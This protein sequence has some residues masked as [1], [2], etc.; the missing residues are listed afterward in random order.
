M[1]Q[2]PDSKFFRIF[3][4]TLLLAIAGYLVYALTG[5]SEPSAPVIGETHSTD[6]VTP[7]HT[8]FTP[9]LR[10]KNRGANDD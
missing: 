6:T 7:P 2:P 1:K 8:P 10:Q 5:D 3:I 4:A 9:R